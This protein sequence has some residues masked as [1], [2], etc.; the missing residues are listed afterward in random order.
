[1]LPPAARS[2]ALCDE[3]NDTPT[4]ELFGTLWDIPR[5]RPSGAALF[6]RELYFIGR[7]VPPRWPQNCYNESPVI[8]IFVIS[9]ALALSLGHHV[10]LLCLAA[11]WL[12]YTLGSGKA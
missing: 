10:T 1:M 5:P 7:K 3:V 6:G 4:A 8:K 11:V 9:T 12:G 2:G